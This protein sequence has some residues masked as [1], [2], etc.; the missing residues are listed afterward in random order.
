[1]RITPFDQFKL[2]SAPPFLD[3]LFAQDRVGHG[4]VKFGKDQP[5]DAVVP[6]KAG[7][8]VR[9]VVPNAASKIRGYADIERT[10][11]SARKHVH[12]RM[13]FGHPTNLWPW[14]PAFRGDDDVISAYKMYAMAGQRRQIV[15]DAPSL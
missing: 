13:L 8:S 6:Y 1:M 10:I 3:P 5:V 14:V 2:P 7:N 9:P 15:R 12:A 11:A 4:L